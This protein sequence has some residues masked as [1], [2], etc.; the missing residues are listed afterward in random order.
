MAGDGCYNIRN[1]FGFNLYMVSSIILVSMVLMRVLYYILRNAIKPDFV[2]YL[3]WCLLEMMVVSF[4]VALYITLI[5]KTSDHF[6]LESWMRTFWLLISS[7]AVPYALLYTVYYIREL[8]TVPEVDEGARIKFYDSRHIL[9]FVTTGSSILYVRADE[10]YVEI[11]YLD[12]GRIR[13]YQLR[14]TLK[15]VGQLCAKAGLVRA[16]RSYLVNPSHVTMLKKEKNGLLYAAFDNGVTE[17]VPVSK[18]YY[19]AL[20]SVL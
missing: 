1:I 14:N 4:F 6:F 12:N 7:L 2:K 9:K 17:T 13:K 5:D 16:H 20:S 19:E 18:K 8:N 10:N 15:S 11:N 3:L